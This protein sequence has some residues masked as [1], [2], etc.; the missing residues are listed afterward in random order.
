MIATRVLRLLACKMLLALCGATA[1]Y[2]QAAP[3]WTVPEIGALPDDDRGRLI[4]RGRDLITATYALLGPNA[5]DPAMRHAGNNLA[6]ANCHLNAGTRRFALP[7]FGLRHLFPQY[8]ARLGADISIEDRVNACMTRSMNGRE[9]P[10][11]GPE[12]RAIV[13]YV[14]FLSTDVAANQ[15]LPGRGAGAMPE[16]ARAADPARGQS[17][18]ARACVA[19]HNTNGSGVPRSRAALQLGYMVPPLWGPDSFN[20]GAGMARL[21]TAANFIHFNMPHGADY[22]HP[23]LT[24]EQAWDVAAY[25][26][27]Q[28]RPRKPD[29][30]QDYPDPLSKPVDAPYGPYADGFSQTQHK[31][32]PFAPIRA[33]IAKLRGQQKGGSPAR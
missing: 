8:N 3:L 6:C 5:S 19:C 20:D 9:L 15:V 1:A 26:L 4:R 7:L 14:D 22:L 32:G 30:D 24:V 12:M 16:L 29:L 10:P 31:Y 18:Y 13:A 2:P 11:D 28:P 23:Q 33:A 27:S 25:M 17:I 21:I